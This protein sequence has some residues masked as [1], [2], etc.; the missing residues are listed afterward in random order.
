MKGISGAQY[1]LCYAMYTLVLEYRRVFSWLQVVIFVS[2]LRSQATPDSGGK[3]V[4][5]RS[6]VCSN[7]EGNGNFFPLKCY[8]N[9]IVRIISKYINLPVDR[10]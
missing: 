7:C 3:T 10:L 5:P 9:P 1:M 6:I 8:I 2:S 4:K